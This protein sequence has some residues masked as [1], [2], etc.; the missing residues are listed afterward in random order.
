[1]LFIYEGTGAQ[2]HKLVGNVKEVKNEA[3]DLIG[4]EKKLEIAEEKNLNL[5]LENTKLK[6]KLQELESKAEQLNYASRFNYATSPAKV[7]GRSPDT[8]HRQIIINKGRKDGVKVGQ[9]VISNK[10]IIGQITK[11]GES[12]SIVQLSQNR[13]WKMGIKIKRTD[14]YGVIVGDYPSDPHLELFPIDSDLQ[15]G[16][17]VLSSGI[18]IDVNSCPYPPNMLVGQ[19]VEVRREPK[20]VDLLVKVALEDDLRYLENVYIIR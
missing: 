4:T 20:Q 12:S 9:G 11:V 3:L 5:E 18:C 8:W 16:D 19:V 1:M 7:I 2:L 6:A 10:S 17:W 14:Q 15:V 13:D